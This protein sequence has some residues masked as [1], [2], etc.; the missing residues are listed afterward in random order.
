MRESIKNRAAAIRHYLN[1]QDHLSVEPVMLYKFSI[2]AAQW[3][4]V[5]LLIDKGNGT[6]ADD[7]RFADL[8]HVLRALS[9]QIGLGEDLTDSRGFL[10]YDPSRIICKTWQEAAERW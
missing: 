3:E 5:R 2:T 6:P 4:A 8:T 1:N 9:K 10:I 7:R